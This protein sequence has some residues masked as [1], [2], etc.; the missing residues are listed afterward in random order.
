M[1]IKSLSRATKS[2]EALYKYLTRDDDSL[3]NTHNLYSSPYDKE[4]LIKEFLENASYL[5]RARGKN[6]LYH[7]IISLNKNNLSL[8]I[9]Q[10]ILTDLCSKYLSLRAGEHLGF[11][12]LHKDKEHVHIHVMI[13]SNEMM[14]QKRVRLSKKDFSN[15]QK[16]LEQYVN[17]AYPQLGNTKHYQKEKN[18]EKSK[19]KEQLQEL[20]KE[21]FER[22]NS[23]DSFKNHMATVGIEFYTRG[24]TVGVIFKGKKYRLKTLG[25][26]EEYEKMVAKLEKEPQEK[27]E[28]KEEKNKTSNENLNQ[29]KKVNSNEESTKI[30]S[31]R[32]EMRKLREQQEHKAQSKEKKWWKSDRF[33]H[34]KEKREAWR[35][36]QAKM[37]LYEKMKQSRERSKK[38]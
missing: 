35:E 26:L 4:A 34:L 8:D 29:D 10:K 36:K 3:L 30:K 24:K 1:I 15:I 7:E 38:E 11:T 6:Y 20:L 19:N 31:R 16:E 9:Q 17:A 23:K 13:S 28:Q 2:F 37:S 18:L 21:L 33:S 32:E 27:Q 12:A 25:L 5:K 22:S 14:G